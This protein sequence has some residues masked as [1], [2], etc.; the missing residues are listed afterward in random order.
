MSENEVSRRS[1]LRSAAAAAGASVL[2]APAAAQ[3]FTK[4][5][6][7]SAGYQGQPNG[8]QR[9]G[10]CRQFQPPAACKVVAGKI[11][12]NGWCRIYAAKG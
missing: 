1:I 3:G 7:T 5:P 2:S 8:G 4:S 9:C 6:Q 10:N 12:A 11:S